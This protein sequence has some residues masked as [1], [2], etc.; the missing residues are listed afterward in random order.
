MMVLVVCGL[1]AGSPFIFA[2][3]TI[4]GWATFFLGMTY[5]EVVKKI[6]SEE[7]LGIYFKNQQALEFEDEVNKHFVALYPTDLLKQGHFQFN[8]NKKL[9][10]IRLVFNEKH[11]SYLMLME[12]LTK[13]YGKPSKVTHPFVE[14]KTGSAKIQLER[15]TTV[16]YIEKSI[17]DEAPIV[18]NKPS[19]MEIQTFESYLGAL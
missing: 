4:R 3:E 2:K 11:F 19:M 14:W 1:M 12:R 17:F 10:L 6:E 16:R 13:K 9:Y 8:K 15:K 5:S 18:K 7:V